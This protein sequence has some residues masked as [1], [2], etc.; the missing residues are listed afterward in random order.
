MIDPT[1]LLTNMFVRLQSKLVHTW[2]EEMQEFLA[3]SQL[4]GGPDLKQAPGP[5]H[6]RAQRVK[7]KNRAARSRIDDSL[8]VL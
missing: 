7:H 3:P 2:C 6:L 5:R 4:E 1:F 8:D